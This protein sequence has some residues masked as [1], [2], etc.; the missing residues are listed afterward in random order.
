MR[1]PRSDGLFEGSSITQWV[2]AATSSCL[3]AVDRMKDD[4]IL[5]QSTSDIVSRFLTDYEIQ[6]PVL[7]RDQIY[8]EPVELQRPVNHHDVIGNSTRNIT[9]HYARFHIPFTGDRNV[10]SMSP[11]RRALF[12]EA[13]AAEAT[14][15][16]VTM[17]IHGTNEDGIKNSLD[18]ILDCVQETLAV[19][20][21]DFAPLASM[22]KEGVWREVEQRRDKAL[23][24]RNMVGSLGFPMKRRPDAPTTYKA[25]EVKR[26]ITP[27]NRP[28]TTAP[29][30]P[31]PT[32]DEAEYQHILNVMD[33][34]TKVMER[35]PHTFAKLGEEA[36]R[37]HFLVQLN[38]QYEGGATGETFNAAGKT[39]ILIRSE[40]NNIFIAECKF[41]KGEGVYTETIDQLLSYT[42]WRDTKTAL[43]IF[44][45]NKN[46]TGVLETIKAATP[47]HQH[48]K[49]AIAEK[50][51]TRFRYIFGHP[52]DWARDIIV[53]VMVYDIPDGKK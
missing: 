19:A 28:V 47:K 11:S 9:E 45:R 52:S 29:F 14:E 40:G 51:D 18:N 25:P 13:I 21:D 23:K 16:I 17:P 50:G 36:I 26:R 31:D 15:L 30:K 48:F 34:M 24:S 2:R 22:I 53:T 43:V 38:S 5:N 20:R 4:E 37:D 39:D 1:G 10:F 49:R 8:V 6:V 46:L 12:Y 32:L 7:H 41:W 44:N 42:T 27:A 35:S 33:S 3:S